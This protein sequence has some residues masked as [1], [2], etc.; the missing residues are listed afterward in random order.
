MSYA[1]G[2]EMVKR[3]PKIH[4]PNHII[5]DAYHASADSTAGY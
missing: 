3:M 1:I 4:I 2:K 5:D